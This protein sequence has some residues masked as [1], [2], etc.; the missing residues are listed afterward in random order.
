MKRVYRFTFAIAIMFALIVSISHLAFAQKHKVNV[1]GGP[2]PEKDWRQEADVENGAGLA[3]NHADVKD[4]ISKWYGPDGNYENNG[5]FQVSGQRD[6]ID[7]GTKG[8]LTEISLST[9]EGLKKTQTIKMEWAKKNGGTREWDVFELEVAN[10]DNMNRDGPAD[11]IDTYVMC[12]IE[13]PKDMKSI[14]SPAHD[15]WAQIWVNGEKWYNDRTWTGGAQIVHYNIE[16]DLVKGGNVVLYRCGESGGAAYLNLHF[17]SD[18]HRLCNIYPDKAKDQKSF[19]NEASRA[20][21][22]DPAGKLTST[23]A[24]I[25]RNQ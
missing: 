25:K 16:V 7:E 15:D 8:K 6:L 19:F 3:E 1:K 5:S 22:V 14:F 24:D 10:Q 21:A 13:A 12:V 18:T 4:W 23:W 20:L 2:I 9:I 17:D 11:N